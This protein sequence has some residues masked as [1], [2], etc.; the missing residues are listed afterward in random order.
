MLASGSTVSR[1]E[2]ELEEF[3][4][5]KTAVLLAACVL[6]FP[7]A[8]GIALAWSR[9]FHRGKR[10]FVS[11]LIKDSCRHDENPQNGDI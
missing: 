10:E 4:T 1:R 2:V 6:A 11:Q 7:A 9:G 3:L 5:M 8:Y